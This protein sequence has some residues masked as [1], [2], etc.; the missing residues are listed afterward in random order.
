MHDAA[1]GERRGRPKFAPGF[2]LEQLARHAVD[3]WLTS[4][5]LPMPD[6]RVTLND[7]NQI[8]LSL[9][10]DESGAARKTAQEVARDAGAR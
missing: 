1:I 2:T 5:D 7:W 4:E 10:V 9:P 3:F 8:Q 6:N